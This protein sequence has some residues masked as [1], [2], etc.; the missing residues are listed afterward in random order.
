M[1]ER[2]CPSDFL[3]DKVIKLLVDDETMEEDHHK[4]TFLGATTLTPGA[5]IMLVP[6]ISLHT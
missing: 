2:G 4:K 6:L 5:K 1:G 3:S